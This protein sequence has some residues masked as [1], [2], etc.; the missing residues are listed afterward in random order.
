MLCSII[1]LTLDFP[2]SLPTLI[3]NSAVS[4]IANTAAIILD[5]SFSPASHLTALSAPAVGNLSSK[6]LMPPPGGSPLIIP[7]IFG[8]GVGDGDG[9]GSG[10]GQQSG[11]LYPSPPPVPSAQVNVISKSNV[12]SAPCHSLP[13]SLSNVTAHL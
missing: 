5:Q 9:D 10:P 7:A 12:V 1:Y 4:I 6:P 2:K 8:E 3:I 11:P 13:V